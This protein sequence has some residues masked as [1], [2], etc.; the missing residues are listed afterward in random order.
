MGYSY[1]YKVETPRSGGRRNRR[2]RKTKRNFKVGGSPASKHVLGLLKSDCKLA[3]EKPIGSKVNTDI[4]KV[5]IY[6]TSG[7]SRRKRTRKTKRN[8]KLRGGSD[9]KSVLYSRGPVNNPGQSQQ[10]FRQFNKTSQF[11]PNDQTNVWARI[12]NKSQAQ[13]LKGGRKKS[14]K[15][16]KKSKK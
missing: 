9:W 16:R 10:F 15:K 6:K 8:M 13:L 5:S 11:V 14:L 7:G 3:V 12:H 4:S 1:P 2:K